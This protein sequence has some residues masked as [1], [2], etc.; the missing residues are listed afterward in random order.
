MQLVDGV[1]ITT[2]ARAQNMSH[3]EIA[4]MMKQV[5]DAVGYMHG[6]GVIHRDLKPS[7]VLVESGGWPQILDFGL[8]RTLRPVYEDLTGLKEG[9]V[10]GTMR[11]M[12]PEIARGRGYP[13]PASDVYSLGVML[14]ELLTGH[15]PFDLGERPKDA[16]QRI[17]SSVPKPPLEFGVSVDRMLEKILMKCLDRDPAKR[18]ADGTALG[19][20]LGAFVENASPALRAAPQ[21]FLRSHGYAFLAFFVAA[22]LLRFFAGVS[23]VMEPWCSVGVVASLGTLLL[24]RAIGKDAKLM[25]AGGGRAHP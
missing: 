12:S 24:A 15:F 2:Y 10:V 8:A 5:A 19:K 16:R 1:S 18:Y 13:K 22:S 21:A 17:L 3:Y 25:K 23:I 20:A 11:Y 14:Y 9:E 4:S 7:N 6:Q